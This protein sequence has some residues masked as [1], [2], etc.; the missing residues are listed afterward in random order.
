M[1]RQGRSCLTREE[2]LPNGE[3]TREE[4]LLRTDDLYKL[5]PFRGG[6]KK[7]RYA[8]VSLLDGSEKA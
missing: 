8:H 2:C 4:S 7:V 5:T 1:A 3:R 6:A